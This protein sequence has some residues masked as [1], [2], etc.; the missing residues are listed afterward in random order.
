[1]SQTIL[2]DEGQK[3][4]DEFKKTRSVYG[5]FIDKMIDLSLQGKDE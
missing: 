4:F 2:T 5:P 3:L 1:V